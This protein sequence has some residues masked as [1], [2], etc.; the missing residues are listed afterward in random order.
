MSLLDFYRAVGLIA[1]ALLKDSTTPNEGMAQDADRL[2]KALIE[3][4][5]RGEG[6]E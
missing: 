2:A 6:H 1:V 3:A 5:K 4:K